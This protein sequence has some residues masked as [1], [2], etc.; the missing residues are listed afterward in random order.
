MLPTVFWLMP[1]VSAVSLPSNR[2]ALAD[3]FLAVREDEVPFRRFLRQALREES[4][5]A[6][7]PHFGDAE[8]GFAR[9]VVDAFQFGEFLE[10]VLMFQRVP[11]LSFSINRLFS[12][13]NLSTSIPCW[14]RVGLPVS[15]RAFQSLLT[16]G[17]LLHCVAGTNMPFFISPPS[18]GIRAPKPTVRPRRVGI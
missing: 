3:A 1:S 16:F 7:R 4:G 13:M 18:S 5:L 2:L 6:Q 10:R 15:T 9:F 8:A 12:R 14:V 11:F 17:W